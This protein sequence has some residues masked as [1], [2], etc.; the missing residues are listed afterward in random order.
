METWQIGIGIALF[1][2][3]MFKRQ[4]WF[5]VFTLSSLYAGVQALASVV[6]LQIIGAFAYSFLM[7]ICW[8]NAIAIAARYRHQQTKK[9]LAQNAPPDSDHPDWSP[10]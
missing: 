9:S 6:H 10:S 2:V 3:L 7:V 4:F 8:S 5:V 1:L